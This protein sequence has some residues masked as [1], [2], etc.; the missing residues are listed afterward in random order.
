MNCPLT[1]TQVDII[2]RLVNGSARKAVAQSMGMLTS[3]LSQHLT[4]AR[5][6]SRTKTNEQLVAVAVKRKWIR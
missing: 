6:A 2:Q 1:E 3:R 4:M 5:A